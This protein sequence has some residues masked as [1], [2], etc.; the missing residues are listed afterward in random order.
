MWMRQA[1]GA[2]VGPGAVLEETAH[3]RDELEA[4]EK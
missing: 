1:T 4:L 2:A 3:A